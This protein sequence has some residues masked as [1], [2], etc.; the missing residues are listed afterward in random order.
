MCIPNKMKKIEMKYA[1]CREK[2][3]ASSLG[4]SHERPVKK[5]RAKTVRKCQKIESVAEACGFSCAKDGGWSPFGEWV[6]CS[7]ECGGGSQTRMRTCDNP[8]PAFG[9]NYCQGD[10]TETKLCNMQ[11][12]PGMRNIVVFIIQW[13]DKVFLTNVKL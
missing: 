6:D 2:G 8:P 13:K 5:L 9:G 12:C 3:F 11:P 1:Q 7:A 4:C 10:D